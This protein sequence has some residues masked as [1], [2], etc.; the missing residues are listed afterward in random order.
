MDPTALIVSSLALGAAYSL[1]A[2]GFVLVLNMTGAVNFAQGELVVAGGFTAI[3]LMAI[4]PDGAWTT[5][6]VL[7]PLTLLVMAVGGA[8]FGGLAYLPLARRSASTIFL[9]SI[10]TAMM[11]QNGL[12][13]LFGPAPRT[14]PSLL[15]GGALEVLGVT[16]SRQS[17]AVFLTASGLLIATAVILTRTRFGLRLRAM[18]E[19]ADMA[20]AM[21]VR[22]TVLRLGAFALAAALAGAAGMMLAHQFFLTPADGAGFMLKAY[23][24]ATVGGWGRLSGAVIGA[25]LIAALETVGASMLG[26]VVAEA[27]LYGLV[28]VV[29]MVRRG[30]L[31]SEKA[32]SR[33]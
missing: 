17:L 30:G 29:L 28:L 8:L 19:D 32:G 9:A 25:F 5:P 33:P 1:V 16:L 24:A 7:L 6:L 23:I 14:T 3:A 26:F 13:G 10:A 15:S 4:V 18:A 12:L 22:V 27:L 11:I 20:A 21:G 2:L 31:L